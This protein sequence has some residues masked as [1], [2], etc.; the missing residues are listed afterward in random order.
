MDMDMDMRLKS[1]EQSANLV[2]TVN[3]LTDFSCAICVVPTSFFLPKLFSSPSF[4]NCYCRKLLLQLAIADLIGPRSSVA[5]VPFHGT[6][7]S[8]LAVP[9]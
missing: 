2:W 4:A 3:V 8:A 7:R 1:A 9:R 5:D 6:P